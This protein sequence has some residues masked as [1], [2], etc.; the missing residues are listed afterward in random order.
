VPG[1]SATASAGV[2]GTA[3]VVVVILSIETLAIPHV[4]PADRLVIDDLGYT[5]DKITHTSARFGYMDQPNVPAV[6]R[7]LETARATAP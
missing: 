7:Q 1:A 2:V 5:D 4:R 3:G 6:M